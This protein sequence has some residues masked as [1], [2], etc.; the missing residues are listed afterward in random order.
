VSHPSVPSELQV[1]CARNSHGQSRQQDR[2]SDA[3]TTHTSVQ[4]RKFVNGC[5]RSS[6]EG[7]SWLS[8]WPNNSVTWYIRN[9][10][11]NR[12]KD[13]HGSLIYSN[14]SECTSSAEILTAWA[15]SATTKHLAYIP[16]EL[17]MNL[18]PHEHR[19]HKKHVFVIM[20]VGKV[21]LTL[22]QSI[23]LCI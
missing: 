9:L 17:V 8:A 11:N 21:I 4:G 19:K 7:P 15:Q 1:S 18:G 10:N 14:C 6:Q 13:A 3:T 23:P 12:F 16:C 20:Q 2:L 22:I 5:R